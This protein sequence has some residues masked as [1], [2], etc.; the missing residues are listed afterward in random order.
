MSLSPVP[1]PDKRRA[2]RFILSKKGMMRRSLNDSS[3]RP[4]SSGATA[5]SIIARLRATPVGVPPPIVTTRNNM[6][7]VAAMHTAP[8]NGNHWAPI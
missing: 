6:T 5:F 2:M 7:Q 1:E 3:L 8:I 4:T